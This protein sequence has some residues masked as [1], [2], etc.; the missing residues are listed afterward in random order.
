[1]EK[2]LNPSHFVAALVYSAVGLGVFMAAFVAVDKATPYNLWEE[3]VAKQNRA[4][5]TVVGCLSI[6]ISIIIAASI[7]G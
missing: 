1:M 3:L 2:L 7:L 5:A 4:L 6:G